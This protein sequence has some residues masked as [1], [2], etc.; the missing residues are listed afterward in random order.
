MGTKERVLAALMES[1]SG[2]SGE[3]LASELGVSRNA[4]WKAVAWATGLK[5]SQ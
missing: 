4:I 5:T 3:R 1:P 2:A